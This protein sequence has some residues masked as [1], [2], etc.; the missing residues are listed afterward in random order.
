MTPFSPIT[1]HTTSRLPQTTSPRLPRRNQSFNHSV[2]LMSTPS[3]NR[4]LAR[5]LKLKGSLTD[6]AQPR[7]R[8]AFGAVCFFSPVLVL[9]LMHFV[10]YLGLVTK[11]RASKLQ[12][13]SNIRIWNLSWLIWYWR[14]R[15]RIWARLSRPATR[16]FLFSQSPRSQCNHN[17]IPNFLASSSAW[18]S[19][20]LFEL[21]NYFCR[22]FPTHGCCPWSFKRTR[23]RQHRG[24]CGTTFPRN[25][26]AT[27]PQPV[28]SRT[29]S[30]PS[31]F[32]FAV[33]LSATS[34]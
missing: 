5:Q 13:E 22:S 18:A 27:D 11:C 19:T 6:P 30:A 1:T 15:F 10:N 7:R 4:A 26:P 31:W 21:N 12:H 8:E 17:R 16:R 23:A 2:N 29:S 14:K 33:L 9:K 34:I 25:P 24:K 28:L 3:P 32:L 20:N